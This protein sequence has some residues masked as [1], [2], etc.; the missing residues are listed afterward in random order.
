M[1]SRLNV[2]ERSG[3]V[4][5][6]LNTKR[7]LRL[8]HLLSSVIIHREKPGGSKQPS[9]FERRIRQHI[10]LLTDK[11]LWSCFSIHAL[12]APVILQTKNCGWMET[13]THICSA[14]LDC[15]F[16]LLGYTLKNN[17]PDSPL[18]C[19]CCAESLALCVCEHV[20]IS[21]NS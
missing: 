14:G 5:Q 17:N 15:C 9:L 3:I 20:T 13:H 6:M 18:L 7:C 16:W 19:L 10:C 21:E 2:R 8:A 11:W 12:R 4:M 1:W